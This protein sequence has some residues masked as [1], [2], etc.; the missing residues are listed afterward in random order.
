MPR[1]IHL[2]AFRFPHQSATLDQYHHREVQ[3]TEEL[4]KFKKLFH[5]AVADLPNSPQKSAGGDVKT[6]GHNSSPS[7]RIIKP[8]RGVTTILRHGADTYTPVPL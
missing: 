6:A 2:M 7:A 5:E 8:I 1:A 4:D 3:L